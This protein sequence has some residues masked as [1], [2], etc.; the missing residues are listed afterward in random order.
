VLVAS[1]AVVQPVLVHVVEYL[2]AHFVLVGLAVELGVP[3]ARALPLCLAMLVLLAQLFVLLL[4]RVVIAMNLQQVLLKM[5]AYRE[6][7]VL[8]VVLHYF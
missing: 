7:Q 3:L 4:I 1:L 6:F 8:K 2:L 5:L